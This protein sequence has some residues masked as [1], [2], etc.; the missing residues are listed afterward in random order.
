VWFDQG[1]RN[2]R[3]VPCGP[4]R[5]GVQ[6]CSEM[7][8]PEHSR[9]L[10]LAGAHLVVQPRATGPGKKWKVASEMGAVGSGCYVISAN[11]PSYPRDWFC[12]NSWLLSP[13]AAILAETAAEQPFVT[14][15]IDLAL[16]EIEVHVSA[17][18]VANER[19]VRRVLRDLY[20]GV[21][22]I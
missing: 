12:G 11:R 10:D 22:S 16:A 17:R 21:A 20:R 18:P 6:M 5:I 2:F 7:M 3:P 8:F 13:E 4:L 9:A 1:D 15:D 14:A 19:R